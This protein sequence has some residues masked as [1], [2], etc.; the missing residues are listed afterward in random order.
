M[1][2][3]DIPIDRPG[4]LAIISVYCPDQVRKFQEYQEFAEDGR[5]RGVSR[6]GVA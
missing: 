3:M 1:G 4:E 6:H 2:A 5:G